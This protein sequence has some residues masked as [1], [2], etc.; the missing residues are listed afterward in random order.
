MSRP[1]SCDTVDLDAHTTIIETWTPFDKISLLCTIIG[2]TT[3]AM[4]IDH[5][6]ATIITINNPSNDLPSQFFKPIEYEE[7][8]QLLNFWKNIYSADLELVICI[9]L[10]NDTG[11]FS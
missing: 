8:R 4:I 5:C 1:I 3:T 10:C 2:T 9:T 7:I 6:Y 11:G